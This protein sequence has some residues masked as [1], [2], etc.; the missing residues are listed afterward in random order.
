MLSGMFRFQMNME[1][2][3]R[4]RDIKP[5]MPVLLGSRYLP[6]E[7]PG[8]IIGIPYKVG[9]SRISRCDVMTYDGV[10]ITASVRNISVCGRR[11]L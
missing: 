9:Y 1:V 7:V 3:M 6:N 10:N 4:A 2:A 8:I 11:S 5:G